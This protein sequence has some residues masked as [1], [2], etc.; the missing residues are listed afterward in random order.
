MEKPNFKKICK[1]YIQQL[2]NFPYIEKDFDALTDYGLLCKI[3]AYLNK[4][5]E[6]QNTQ[7]ESIMLL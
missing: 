7:N 1:M 3:V 2:T 4:V 5:I 6:N